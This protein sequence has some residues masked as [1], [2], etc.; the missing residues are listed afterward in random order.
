MLNSP[1]CKDL[2]FVILEIFIPVI[3]VDILLS[4][5]SILK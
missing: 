3:A 5:T 4:D 2:C 1:E